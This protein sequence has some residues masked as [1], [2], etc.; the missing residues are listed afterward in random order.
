MN[1]VA[2]VADSFLEHAVGGRVGDHDGRE[3]S[4]ML[5]GLGLKIVQIDVAVLIAGHDDHLHSSHLRSGRIGAVSRGRNQADVAPAFASVGVIGANRHHAG[6][7]ALRTGVGLER[8]RIVASAGHQHFFQRREQFR[9]ALGLIGWCERMQVSELRPGNR[10]HFRSGVQLHGAGT[11]RNHA[12]IQRQI[13][14]S[15]EAQIAQHLGFRVIGVEHR[16]GQKRG[17][18]S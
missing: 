11:E 18:A 15:E 1:H 13:T 17:G 2:N 3:I 7:F 16:M 4:G 10:D 14:V 6:V 12:T 5:L 8:Y 9:I